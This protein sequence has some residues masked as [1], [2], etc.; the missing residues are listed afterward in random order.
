[1]ILMSH[2]EYVIDEAAPSRN[3][4]NR[5]RTD[6]CEKQR[7]SARSLQSQTHF[8]RLRDKG[9]GLR[10]L[11]PSGRRSPAHCGRF[12]PQRPKKA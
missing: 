2:R 7:N 10:A 5:R 3:P 8:T 9:H 6:S 11:R 1:M 12:R 4:V